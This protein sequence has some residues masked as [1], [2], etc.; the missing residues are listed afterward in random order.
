M[1]RRYVLIAAVVAAVIVA[2]LVTKAAIERGLALGASIEVIPG[3]FNLV[4]WRNTGAAFGMLGNGGPL[5]TY[6]LMAVNVVALGVIAYL[7]HHSK[8]TSMDLALSLVAG[9]AVGNLIDRVRYGEVVDFL[10]FHIG[11]LHWPAF[12]VADSAITTGVV[13]LIVLIITEPRSL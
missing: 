5:V 13:L 3:F 12:N 10:D 4:S 1:H 2:D 9:G 8:K 6:L 7:I 11:S